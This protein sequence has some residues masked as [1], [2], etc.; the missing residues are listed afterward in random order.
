[1]RSLLSAIIVATGCL[2]N[3]Q[4]AGTVKA[5]LLLKFT[6]AESK[7]LDQPFYGS[8][9]VVWPKSVTGAKPESV[10]LNL[11]RPADGHN[12][13][14]PIDT[15]Y[16]ATTE[17]GISYWGAYA[18]R[19][20][21][22]DTSKLTSFS[23]YKEIVDLLGAPTN[24][25]IG[26]ETDDKWAFDSV[27]WRLFSP[28]NINSIEVLEVSVA[29]K[30][31]IAHDRSAKYLIDSYSV[32]RGTLTKSAPGAG[33]PANRTKSDSES[34]EFDQ[35][36]FE[37][38]TAKNL[39]FPL[40]EIVRRAKI[41]DSEVTKAYRCSMKSG[42]S[43]EDLVALRYGQ[44]EWLLCWRF[45]SGPAGAIV[46]SKFISELS[47]E[48][49]RVAEAWLLIAES[50]DLWSGPQ[51]IG[52]PTGFDDG[53]RVVVA[54]FANDAFSFRAFH[55]S[56]GIQFPKQLDRLTEQSSK[57]FASIQNKQPKAVQTAPSGGGTL[58]DGKSESGGK[59]GGK[60][61][62][63]H[64][65]PLK[66]VTGFL[67]DPAVTVSP[68]YGGTEFRVQFGHLYPHVRPWTFSPARKESWN[69][70]VS[71][72]VCG[73][74]ETAYEQAFATYLKIDEKVRRDQYLE[75][76]KHHPGPAPQ[77]DGAK[78]DATPAGTLD[79]LPSDIPPP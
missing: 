10:R 40:K 50:E 13:H 74:C 76:L 47:E 4:D 37:T 14:S 70:E 29:R 48:Q 78:M 77:D 25:P 42:W 62:E 39:V 33:Q 46:G 32:K 8:I 3:G 5:S 26:G 64:H 75:F 58:P 79:H 15:P 34:G 2:V 18:L 59:G 55:Q 51:V 68:E 49:K 60:A 9:L 7:V 72:E 45:D 53:W 12:G 31:P 11:M 73:E 52:D 69:L 24:L 65:Q 28:S 44:G 21:L 56:N 23:S 63:F 16:L 27:S 6:P 61:C 54:R 36:D 35:R 1:M 22:P 38:I 19:P 20:K 57:V 17:D 71:I 67:P 30:S 43:F 41:E 66:R